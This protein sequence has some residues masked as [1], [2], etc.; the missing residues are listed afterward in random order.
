MT[1]QIDDKAAIP[2]VT[3]YKFGLLYNL[4]VASNLAHIIEK[5]K[6][7]NSN[8]VVK[9]IRSIIQRYC[10]VS[11]ATE[12]V[13]SSSHGI[14]RWLRSSLLINQNKCMQGRRSA[15]SNFIHA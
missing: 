14:S 9:P 15:G 7:I 1:R 8:A 13:I 6:R 2:N 4:I 12:R 10:S 11:S 3:I 5:A